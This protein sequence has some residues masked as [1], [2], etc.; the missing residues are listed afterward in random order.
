MNLPFAPDSQ[1][2][3]LACAALPAASNPFMGPPVELD[4]RWAARCPLGAV[5]FIFRS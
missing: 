4:S 1:H 3:A 2:P 5:R